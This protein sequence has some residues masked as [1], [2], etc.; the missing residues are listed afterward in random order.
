M[1]LEIVLLGPEQGGSVEILLVGGN[2]RV[3]HGLHFEGLPDFAV[4]PALSALRGSDATRCAT[5]FCE[6]RGD[7]IFQF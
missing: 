4:V 2:G 6:M 5:V 1:E 7:T 3:G